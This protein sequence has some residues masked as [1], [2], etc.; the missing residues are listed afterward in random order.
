MVVGG[1]PSQ[2][3][4]RVLDMDG[5]PMAGGAVSLYQALYAWAPAC[6]VHGRCA[7]AELLATQVATATSALDGTVSFSPASLPSVATNLVALAVAGN[8]G[9]VSINVEQSP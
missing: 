5:N 8:T 2:I 3:V 6:P 1:T 7:Q 9:S 4:L